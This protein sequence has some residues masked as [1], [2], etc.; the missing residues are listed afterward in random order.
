MEY[1]YT[2]DSPFSNW[3]PCKY[4]L[5]G[6][7]FYWVEQG[8]MYDKALL[9]N[10]QESMKQI[11]KFKI[12]DYMKNKELILYSKECCR[13]IKQLGRKVKNFESHKWDTMKEKLVYQHCHAKFT[14]NENLKQYL[15]NTFPNILC[16]AS[17]YDKIWGI[18][19]SEKQAQNVEPSEFKGQNLLGKLL[20]KVRDNITNKQTPNFNYQCE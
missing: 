10:D 17:P 8:M 9:M 19:M 11:M 20:T 4:K 6:L 15:I 1:F 5:G 3:H 2:T 12:P 18:G 14:Q 13:R 16:E 7:V